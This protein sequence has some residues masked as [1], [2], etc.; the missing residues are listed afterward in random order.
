MPALAGC[1][2][3]GNVAYKLCDTIMA[4]VSVAM[5]LVANCYEPTSFSLLF[6]FIFQFPSPYY[7]LGDLIV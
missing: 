6:S 2:K 4:R 5:R 3:G 1:G 7:D